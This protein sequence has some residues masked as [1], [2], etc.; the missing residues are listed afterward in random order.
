MKFRTLLAAGLLLSFTT[1]FASE[2]VVYQDSGFSD[3]WKTRAV[4]LGG[5]V[6]GVVTPGAPTPAELQAIADSSNGKP[7]APTGPEAPVDGWHLTSSG[8]VTCNAVSPG[9]TGVVNGVTYT[10]VT[11]A[12]LQAK[13][14]STNSVFYET[15]CTSLV[16]DMNVENS[17]YRGVLSESNLNPS[18]NHWDVSHVTDMDNLFRNASAFNTPLSNWDTSSVTNMRDMFRGATNFNQPLNFDT[19]NVTVINH[20]FDEAS[21]F[22]QDISDW[23]VPLISA[24]PSYFDNNSGFAGQTALQP[25]W[26]TCPP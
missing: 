14:G 5:I 24:K 2:V 9:E 15:A 20:I 18:I 16:T 23:C 13:I 1:A 10:A 12:D 6:D 21:E 3:N 19:S 8:V 26:G 25:Q 11:N 4:A 22:N 7:P 17:N